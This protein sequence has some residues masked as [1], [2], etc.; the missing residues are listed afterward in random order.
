MNTGSVRLFA[1][2]LA[3]YLFVG[4]V[5][6][7]IF[8]LTAGTMSYF[9]GWMYIISMLTV[10]GI[11]FT[12]L[13]IKHKE[14]LEKR[15]R[16]KEKEKEQK[17]FVLISGLLVSG[18]Y[19]LPGFDFRY[20]WTN[21]PMWLSV[22]SMIIVMV[23]YGLNVLVMIQNSYASRTVEIQ[24]EQKVID[25]GMYSIVR[26]PMYL[27]IIPIYIFSPLALGSYIALI[28]GALFPFTLILRIMNE[29]KV[30]IDGLDGYKEYMKKVKYRLIPYIW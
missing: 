23:F 12:V 15:M 18:L 6:G 1:S 10:M 16:S 20:K 21:V 5:L 4:I 17:A 7:C 22:V 9:N 28:A 13:F 30:L 27:V 8:F 29:E 19:I 11:G 2:V 14:V 26:H 24:K 3:R 25:T